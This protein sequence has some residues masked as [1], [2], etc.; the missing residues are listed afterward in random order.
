MKWRVSTD[1]NAEQSGKTFFD[2]VSVCLKPEE[3]KGKGER[4]KSGGESV[5]GAAFPR[6]AWRSQRA[7]SSLSH[8]TGGEAQG[9]GKGGWDHRDYMPRY[10][11]RAWLFM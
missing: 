5:G 2:Q 10:R 1:L 7:L 3:D 9:K 11:V 8:A 6:G 4:A